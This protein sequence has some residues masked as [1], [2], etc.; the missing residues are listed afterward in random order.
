MF[1]SRK[2]VQL[3]VKMQIE[4]DVVFFIGNLKYSLFKIVRCHKDGKYMH[5]LFKQIL[6]KSLVVAFIV[7]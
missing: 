1:S 7:L 5:E 2:P 4:S 3:Y 6:Y